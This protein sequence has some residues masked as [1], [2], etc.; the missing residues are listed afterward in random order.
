M[1]TTDVGKGM[2]FQLSTSEKGISP[3]SLLEA[4]WC[5]P[6]ILYGIRNEIWIGPH[7]QS[8]MPHPVLILWAE[9]GLVE[10][11]TV[12]GKDEAQVF[13]TPG[14]ITTIRLRELFEYEFSMMTQQLEGDKTT[15]PEKYTRLRK[16]LGFYADEYLEPIFTWIVQHSQRKRIL[17]YGGGDGFYLKKLLDSTQH[18]VHGYES[19]GILYDKAPETPDQDWGTYPIDYVQGNFLM[20][21]KFILRH[22][23]EFDTIIFS[24]VLHCLGPHQYDIVLPKLTRLLAPDGLIFIIEQGPSF[25]MNWRLHDMTDGGFSLS[26]EQVVDIFESRPHL[27]LQVVEQITTATHYAICVQHEEAS[28]AT[29]PH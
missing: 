12:E 23:H 29:K 3:Y 4:A 27:G 8:V 15:Y 22:P 28:H 18:E 13:L 25:R 17:D 10:V 20:S 14:G 21:D 9:M 2:A 1:S 7:K 24:E 26:P 11:A 5:L 6:A 19:T 16:A